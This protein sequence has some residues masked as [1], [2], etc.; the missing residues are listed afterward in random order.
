MS[1]L[2]GRFLAA[3]NSAVGLVWDK[4]EEIQF[5]NLQRSEM[6]Q[7]FLAISLLTD[8]YSYFSHFFIGNKTCSEGNEGR[9]RTNS[10]LSDCN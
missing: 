7:Y 1:M 3:V 9:D 4:S 5:L 10:L 6:Y 8:Y 2:A